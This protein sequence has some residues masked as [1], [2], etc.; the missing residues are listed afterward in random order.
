MPCGKPL[1]KY[2][3]CR[4]ESPRR[5]HSFGEFIFQTARGN[6]GRLLGRNRLRRHRL[7]VA[8]HVAALA[9]E[10]GGGAAQQRDALLDR[11][12]GRGVLLAYWAGCRL[13]GFRFCRVLASSAAVAGSPQESAAFVSAPAASSARMITGFGFSDA[14]PTINGVMPRV[15]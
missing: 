13:H 12:S 4:F 10:L 11:R 2:G 7:V 15:S 8:S 1:S 6:A 3:W 9:K 5:V 14:A